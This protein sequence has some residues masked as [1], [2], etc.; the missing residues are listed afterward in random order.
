MGAG[1]AKGRRRGLPA[2]N[3]GSK[4]EVGHEAS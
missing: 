3:I 4:S 1:T 2:T